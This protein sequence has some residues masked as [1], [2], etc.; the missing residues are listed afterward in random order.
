MGAQNGNHK[1]V[2]FDCVGLSDLCDAPCSA[3]CSIALPEA[4]VRAQ[5]GRSQCKAGPRKTK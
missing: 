5:Y 2:Q 4:S 3:P 1:L